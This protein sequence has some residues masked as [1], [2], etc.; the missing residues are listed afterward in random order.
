[1]SDLNEVES[2]TEFLNRLPGLRKAMSESKKFAE[3]KAKLSPPLSI[4]GEELYFGFYGDVPVSED[5]LY[6]KSLLEGARQSLPQGT[7]R[8]ESGEIYKELFD[9][10]SDDLKSAIKDEAQKP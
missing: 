6:L 10:L 2:A 4:D 8:K 3:L 7:Q 9:E 1:M 5:E